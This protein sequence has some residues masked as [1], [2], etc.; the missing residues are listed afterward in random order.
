MVM[1]DDDDGGGGEYVEMMTNDDDNLDDED[2]FMC[3]WSH[4]ARRR[5]RGT[6]TSPGPR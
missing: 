1:I 6:V 3:R 5:W 2:G 4:A